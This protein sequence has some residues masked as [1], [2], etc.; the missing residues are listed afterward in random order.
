MKSA[1]ETK[2]GALIGLGV[3]I[4]AQKNTFKEWLFGKKDDQGNKTQEGILGQFKNM[5]EV[6]VMRPL[7]NSM[8]NFIDDAKYELRYQ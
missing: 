1:I 8:A 2:Y 4:K 3:S 7:K 6:S 5:L